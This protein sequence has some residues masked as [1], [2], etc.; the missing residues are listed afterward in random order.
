MNDLNPYQSPESAGEPEKRP[1]KPPNRYVVALCY[2]LMIFSG[3]FMHAFTIGECAYAPRCLSQIK[4]VLWPLA[5]LL[6]AV[7]AYLVWRNPA[8]RWAAA[9]AFGCLLSGVLASQ[10]ILHFR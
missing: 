10:V 8:S 4:V 3:F 6:G 9:V 2:G 7:M 1:P 5:A